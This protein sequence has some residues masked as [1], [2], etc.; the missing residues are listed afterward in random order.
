[1]RIV[2]IGGTGLIGKKLLRLLRAQGHEAVAASPS[3]GV[4]ALTGEGLQQA[5]AGADVVVDVSNSPSFEDTAVI[6]FFTTS[7]RNLLHA[8][9]AAGVRRHVAA[10][11]VGADR[12]PDSGYLRAKL[13]QEALIAS[14]PV[15]YTILRVTQF[16]EFIESIAGASTTADGTVRVSSSL[17][18]PVAADDVAAALADLAVAP[19]VNGIVELAGP[20]ALPLDALIRRVFQA[21]SDPRTVIADKD[22][23]YF[24]TPITDDS[25]TPGPSPRLGATTLDAW[26]ARL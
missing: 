8:E 2:A 10:S 23:P 4:N 3:G 26:L 25:L 16:F 14:G 5:L 18:Q 7:T 9:A 13:A 21:K 11:V 6:H 20:D 19:P 17:L 24:G 22:A 1:M 15:P 12:L